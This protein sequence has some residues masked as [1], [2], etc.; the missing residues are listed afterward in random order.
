[1]GAHINVPLGGPRDVR[2]YNMG[3]EAKSKIKGF[4]A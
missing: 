4:K 2:I 3:E 1:M